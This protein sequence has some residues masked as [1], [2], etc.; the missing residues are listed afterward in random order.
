MQSQAMTELNFGEKGSV[1]TSLSENARGLVGSEILK[2]A[3][4]IRKMQADG[5]QVCNLTVGDFDTS[6]FPIPAGFRERIV[7]AL[8]AGET[9]YPP[10][11]GLLA[12]REAVTEFTAR[13]WGARYPVESVLIASGARPILYG[14]YRTV[15]N[16]GDKVVYPVPSWNNN[17]YCWMSRAE[18]VAISTRAED[19]FMPTLDQLRPHLD[20]ARMICINSP[21]NPTGTVMGQKAFT[22]ILHAIVEQNHKRAREGRPALFL[23]HDQP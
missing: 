12:L 10:S 8:E 21:L 2:I 22:E 4:D 6:Q 20:S 23:L 17:H 19:G 16:P 11:D 7:A 3:A 15:V 1:E 14:A 18:G 13:N 5:Q 9:N